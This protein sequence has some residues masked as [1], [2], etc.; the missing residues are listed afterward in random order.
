MTPLVFIETY[1]G[2]Q[3]TLFMEYLLV[4]TSTSRVGREVL[5]HEYKRYTEYPMR[6]S[7]IWCFYTEQKN[8]KG[9][10]RMHLTPFLVMYFSQLTNKIHE[11]D[12]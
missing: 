3:W 12:T 7:L 11:K 5:N 4:T 2:L 1:N 6:I 8:E 10:Y 9:V